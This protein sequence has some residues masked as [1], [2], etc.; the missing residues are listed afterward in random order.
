MVVGEGLKRPTNV[1][2]MSAV[3]SGVQF[4]IGDGHNVPRYSS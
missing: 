3:A 1:R 4:I 2:L